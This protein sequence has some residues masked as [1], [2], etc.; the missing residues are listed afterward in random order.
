MPVPS[1]ASIDYP[2]RVSLA[3]AATPLQPLDRLSG[4]VGGPRIWVKRDDLTGF[5]LSGNK[6]RKLEFC[7]GD[8]LAQGCDTLITCGGVQSNHCRATAVAARQLGLD[9]HLVLRQDSPAVADGNLF[10]DRLLG[11]DI[12]LLQRGEWAARLDATCAALAADCAR[13]GRKAYTMP[14]GASDEVGLW[15]Y[16]AAAGELAEDFAGHGI[17]PGHIVCAT[18]SGGTQGGLSLGVLLHGI[19]ARVWGV[20]VCD[21]EDYFNRKIREDVGRWQRRYGGALGPDDVAVATIDGYVGPGYARATPAV[22]DVIALVARTEGLLLDPI[23][24]GKAFFGMLEEIK[25]GRRFA[26]ADD[27]VFVHTGGFFAAYSQRE[28]FFA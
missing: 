26:G 28:Q 23:Y 27:I 19:D 10:I 9:V 1:A 12:T 18:G 11:A 6:V 15:G 14:V 16:I 4:L 21:D 13:R 20:N 22:F 24:T 2:A 8:A 5:G 25:S 7:I 17:A 3:R